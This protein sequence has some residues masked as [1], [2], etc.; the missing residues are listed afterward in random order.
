MQSSVYVQLIVKYVLGSEGF[1]TFLVSQDVVSQIVYQDVHTR[2][3][4]LSCCVKWVSLSFG[5]KMVCFRKN[6]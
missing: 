1:G 4:R 3:D 5:L 2:R 6:T